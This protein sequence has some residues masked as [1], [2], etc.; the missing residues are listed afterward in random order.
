M[1]TELPLVFIKLFH[2]CIIM[3]IV[4]LDQAFHMFSITDCTYQ[5]G[6][7]P[8]LPQYVDIQ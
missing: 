3:H 7:S 6:Y 8:P 1:Y 4:V 2:R 5:Q